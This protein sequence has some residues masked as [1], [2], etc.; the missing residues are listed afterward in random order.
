MPE[1]TDATTSSEV[2]YVSPEDLRVLIEDAVAAGS[3]SSVDALSADMDDAISALGSSLASSSS[4][5][6][7][8]VLDDAQYLQLRS[9]FAAAM[10]SYVVAIGVL[11]LILGAV[12]ALGFTDHWKS[13]G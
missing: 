1:N 11:A 12:V 3:A 9:D 4:T 7:V 13:R 2:V 10:T 5:S 6:G 8:V